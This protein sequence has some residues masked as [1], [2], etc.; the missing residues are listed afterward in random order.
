MTND[1]KDELDIL[2]EA[3]EDFVPIWEANQ[4]FKNLL[5]ARKIISSLLEKEWVSLWWHESWTSGNCHELDKSE[6]NVAIQNLGNDIW[7]YPQPEV[8]QGGYYSIF[9]TPKGLSHYQN[10]PIART[11]MIEEWEVRAAKRGYL[12]ESSNEKLT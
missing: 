12:K 9:I 6:I 8:D 10:D 5:Q 11:Y 2:A 1:E 3:E 7:W 4:R